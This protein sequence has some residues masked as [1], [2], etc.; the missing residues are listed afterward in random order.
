MNVSVYFDCPFCDRENSTEFDLGEH[1]ADLT[2]CEHC[3]REFTQE[4][5]VEIYTKI[6]AD[7]MGAA[8]DRATDRDR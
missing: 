5:G 6:E 3:G 2:E 1:F 8:I 4:Q 7:A